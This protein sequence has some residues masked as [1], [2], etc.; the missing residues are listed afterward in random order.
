MVLKLSPRI[1]K[2]DTDPPP[3]VNPRRE[4]RPV[5]VGVNRK[6]IS[7]Y[8]EHLNGRSPRDKFEICKTFRNSEYVQHTN[9]V[10]LHP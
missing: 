9:N 3:N 8:A 2:W 7:G 5:A 6:I 1:L 4:K 10:V